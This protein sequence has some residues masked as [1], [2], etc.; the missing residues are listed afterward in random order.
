MILT[1]TDN[2]VKF[3]KFPS[4]KNSSYHTGKH[5]K[6]FTCDYE[7]SQNKFEIEQINSEQRGCSH[8]KENFLFL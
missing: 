8:Q 1:S 2:F 6:I 7:S 5:P 4:I 3:L